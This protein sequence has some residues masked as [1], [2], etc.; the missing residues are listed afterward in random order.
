MQSP[1]GAIH[2]SLTMIVCSMNAVCVPPLFKICMHKY[3]Q[4]LFSI[5]ITYE[6][7]RYT[8]YIS[9][10]MF[11]CQFS[12]FFAPANSCPDALVFIGRDGNTIGAAA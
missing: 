1:I 11:A 6:A 9:V 7:G 12:K 8:D 4:N 2:R 3:I 5:S 10:I